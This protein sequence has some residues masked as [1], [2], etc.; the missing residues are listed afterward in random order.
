[1]EEFN[2]DNLNGE[3]RGAEPEGKVVDAEFEVEEDLLEAVGVPATIDSQ[4]I[5]ALLHRFRTE[6]DLV[7]GRAKTLTVIRDPDTNATAAEWAV[8]TK[9][10]I[11]DLEELR[12]RIVTPYNIYLTQVNRFFKL[13]SD[14]LGQAEAYLSRLLGNYRQYQE[15][16]AKRIQAEQEAEA[17]KIQKQLEDEAREAAKKDVHYEPAPIVA[18]VAPEV[19]KVTRVA[20]GSTSQRK[21]WTFEVEDES[22]IDRE[23]LML[24]EKKLREHI[25]GGLRTTPGVRIYEEYTTRIRA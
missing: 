2:W 24:N 4:P 20:G 25:K 1:M 11:K 6:C 13:Y 5:A 7:V 9:R 23:F 16:E 18:P 22:K 21:D 3:E 12:K 8:Q 14:P 17:R 10:K 15:N 19:Q